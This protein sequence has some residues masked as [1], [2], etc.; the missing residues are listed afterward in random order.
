MP[1]NTT[2][3]RGPS[4]SRQSVSERNLLLGMLALQLDFITREQLLAAAAVWMHDKRVLLG[5]VLEQQGALSS[6]LRVM[7]EALA[8]KH[9][10]AHA[11]DPSQSLAAMRG[12]EITFEELTRLGDPEVN[13][14][15]HRLGGGAPASPPSL[16]STIRVDSREI[17]G[18]R[19]RIVRLHAQGGLGRLLAARDEE[20]NREVAIKEIRPERADDPGS[21]QRFLLEAEITGGLEHPGVAPVYCL[22]RFADGRPFYAMRFI[23]GDS[24]EAALREFR[25]KKA[26]AAEQRLALR[27][28]LAQLVDVC[29]TLEY[30]HTRGVLHRDIKPANIM[31]GP[32]GETLLVDWGLAKVAGRDDDASSRAESPLRPRSLGDSPPTID[33]C[34]VGTPAYMSPEQAEGRVDALGPASDVYSLGA[35]LFYILTGRPPIAAKSTA[36][37]LEQVRRG[38]LLD[39]RTIDASVPRPL[40]AICRKAMALSPAARYARAADLAE[41]LERYLADEPVSA[42][43]ESGPE[44]AARWLRRHKSWTAAGGVA[45][46]LVAIVSCAAAIVVDRARDRA[47]QLAGENAALAESE[48]TARQET[49]QRRKEALARLREARAAVDSWL[50]TA[51]V[52]LEQ[53]PGAEPTRLQLLEQAAAAYEWFARSGGE[54]AELQLEAARA[55]LRLGRVY[56]LLGDSDAAEAQLQ[57]AETTVQELL[58]AGALAEEANLE[59]ANCRTQWALLHAFGNRFEEAERLYVESLGVLRKAVSAGQATASQQHALGATLLNYGMLKLRLGQMDNAQEL[60]EQGAAAL[61]EVLQNDPAHLEAQAAASTAQLLLGDLANRIGDSATARRHLEQALKSFE[62]LMGDA[63]EPEKHRN[64]RAE[65]LVLLAG[66]LRREADHRGELEMYRQA[67]ADYEALLLNRSLRLNYVLTRADYAQLLLETGQATEA[68]RGLDAA[69][70]EIL[71]LRTVD[72]DDPML[73]ELEAGIRDV[74]GSAC[75][76][77]G[78][79]EDARSLHEAA[80]ATFQQLAAAHPDVPGYRHR[81]A[82]V[83]SHLGQALHGL[84]LFPEAEDAFR[85][86]AADL[87]ELISLA[88]LPDYVRDAGFIQFHLGNLVYDQDRAEDAAE[89]YG[90]ARRIWQDAANRWPTPEHQQLLAWLLACCPDAGRRDPAEARRLAERMRAGESENPQL[91]LVLGAAAVRAGDLDIAISA[92]R[93]AASLRLHP[94]PRDAYLLSLALLKQGNRDAALAAFEDAEEWLANSRPGNW[95]LNQLRGEV[96]QELELGA[97]DRSDD[98]SGDFTLEPVV[99]AR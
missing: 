5:E 9:I 7:L 49:E 26:G 60:L 90:Q 65:T 16:E 34:V 74:R 29:H 21:R 27:R 80:I 18:N 56:F 46:V 93:K 31:L 52:R 86:A 99:S 40:A 79:Y 20:L 71:A 8:E 58:S 94:D 88:E 98:S 13:A 36:E 15:L 17:A 73:L 37:A 77:V 12:L 42:Y 68:A 33:G 78:R 54:D 50:T 66:V 95:E 38:A 51:A 28:H 14:S 76:D 97:A 69:L 96:A 23:R 24:L 2:Y 10:Q 47:V 82:V 1:D 44:R 89:A 67:L 3:A 55:R 64:S 19:F 63:A 4:S 75:R 70:Q 83:R 59:L 35:T 6:E 32:Y 84:G 72:P 11:N 39:A 87:N 45:V 85:A 41:D 53:T 92:L 62:A 91:Q 48:R 43:R 25:K 57:D 30:A 61:A 81:L 22:G